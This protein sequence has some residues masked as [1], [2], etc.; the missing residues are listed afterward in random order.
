[1]TRQLKNQIRACNRRQRKSS[2]SVVAPRGK[3][4]RSGVLNKK[5]AQV[6]NVAN[7]TKVGV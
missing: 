4:A 1:M 7:V 6:K 5:S 3:Q 2:E